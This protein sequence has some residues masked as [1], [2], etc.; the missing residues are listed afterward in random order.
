MEFA[1]NENT[2]TVTI[3]TKNESEAQ[4]RPEEEMMPHVQNRESISMKTL[5]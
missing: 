3:K 4:H 1:L 2:P 5:I